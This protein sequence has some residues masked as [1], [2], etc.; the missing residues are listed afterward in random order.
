MTGGFSGLLGHCLVEWREDFARLELTIDTRHLNL[1]GV[2]HGGV[3]A[4]MLDDALGYA[5]IYSRALNR[6]RNAVTLSF[7]ASFI[8]QAR[9]GILSCEARRRGGGNTI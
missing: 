7:T 5:G 6:E 3:L 1:S 2:V 8:G 4:A 9:S